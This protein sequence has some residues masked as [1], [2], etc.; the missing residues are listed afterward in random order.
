[1]SDLRTKLLKILEYGNW[2]SQQ[3]VDEAKEA[4]LE[5]LTIQQAADAALQVLQAEQGEIVDLR[6]ENEGLHSFIYDRDK[7]ITELEAELAKTAN[8]LTECVQGRLQEIDEWKRKYE[9]LNTEML[10]WKA[11]EEKRNKYIFNSDHPSDYEDLYPPKPNDPD[12]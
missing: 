11:K 4:D 9:A 6:I 10:Y 1:M 12:Q 3:E 5:L 7:R 2:P 8:Q